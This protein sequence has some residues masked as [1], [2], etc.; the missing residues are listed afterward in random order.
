MEATQTAKHSDFDMVWAGLQEVRQI[1]KEAAEAQKEWQRE[2]AEAQKEWQR[3]AAAERKKSAE[4]REKSAK[5]REKDAEERKKSAEDF[6]RRLGALTNLFGDVTESM[7]APHLCEKFRGIGLDFPKAN[8]NSIVNDRVNSIFIEI[9]IMLE[10]GDKAMLVEA[11]TKL[12]VER[13]NKHIERLEKMRNYA[14]LHGDKRIFLGAVAG[15]VVTDEVRNYA[16][17]QGFYLI[18]PSG[19][20]YNITPP[21]GQPKEW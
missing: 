7:L 5:E 15:I 14:N 4:E 19:D 18:E 8:P 6:N 17:S 11:K 3:E 20:S 16:L 2:A 13:I 9:D 10:N 21:N 1:L 12:T